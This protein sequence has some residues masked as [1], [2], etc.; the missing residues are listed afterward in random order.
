MDVLGMEYD[1]RLIKD[2]DPYM[3]DEDCDG[4]C[5]FKKKEIRVLDGETSDTTL[6][7]EV[8]HAFLYESGIEHGT[9]WHTE[10]CVTWLSLQIPKIVTATCL[11]K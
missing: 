10:E 2:K 7:H 8:I 6:L 5:D 1:V 9:L 11:H 3:I 4:Y